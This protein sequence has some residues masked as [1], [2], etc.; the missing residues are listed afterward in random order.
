M[1]E[2]KTKLKILILIVKVKMESIK[3]Q[4]PM[5]IVGNWKCNGNVYTIN[6]LVN[7]VLNK[8][9]YDRDRL[10]VVIMPVGLHISSVKALL[11]SEIN[12]GC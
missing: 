10:E 12:I 8:A 2:N 3:K 4:R 1:T 7:E 6:A 9:K 11:T 5:I